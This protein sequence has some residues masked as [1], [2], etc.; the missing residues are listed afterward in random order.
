MTS[1][2]DYDKMFMYWTQD[3]KWEGMM[4]VEWLFIKDVPFKEFKNIE[5]MM[6]Y[7]RFNNFI[8]MDLESQFLIQETVR[9]SR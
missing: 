9:R 5:I 4:G 6:K 8:E 3:G 7:N 1:E 2:V